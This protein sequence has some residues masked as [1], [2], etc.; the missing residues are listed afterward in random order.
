M[1][2]N[3]RNNRQAA[4]DKVGNIREDYVYGSAARRLQPRRQDEP[5]ESL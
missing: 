1:S 3:R 4:Y 5:A 2:Q